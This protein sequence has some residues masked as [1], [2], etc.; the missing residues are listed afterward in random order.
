MGFLGD[1]T[2]ANKARK[3]V[4]AAGDANRAQLNS[5][6]DYVSNLY[7]PMRDTGAQAYGTLA[8][9]AGLNGSN[10][11]NSAMSL[12]RTDPGYNFRFDEG[13]RALD[14]SYAARSGGVPTGGM[15]KA[16][17]KYGQGVADQSYGDWRNLIERISNTGI[18]ATNATANAKLGVGQNIVGVNNTEASGLANAALANG[19][20]LSNLIG[21]GL[22][23][24][25]NA[26]GGGWN[27]FNSS[28]GTLRS[29]DPWN[30][31]R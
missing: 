13:V 29:N 20:F 3:A 22:G 25:G 21:A 11:A 12:F 26:V 14:N 27:P 28:G 24:A 2:G 4:A 19:S 31:L 9:L 23:F 17:T 30:G 5:D 16:L 10:A 8:D 18:N 7:Q 15:L 1:L 6:F